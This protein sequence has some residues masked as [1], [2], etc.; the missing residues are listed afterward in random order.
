MAYRTQLSE[1][2]AARVSETIRAQSSETH[3]LVE[4]HRNVPFRVGE[5]QM[6]M[7]MAAYSDPKVR[8]ISLFVVADTACDCCCSR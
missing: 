6:S 3:P 5:V 4:K 7:Q 1:L 2:I 8:G